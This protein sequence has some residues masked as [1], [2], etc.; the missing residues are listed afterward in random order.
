MS[1]VMTA[2]GFELRRQS[3]AKYRQ[4][5]IGSGCCGT[6]GAP[7]LPL[8]SRTRCPR[9]LEQHRL[10]QRQ[11][12]RTAEEK[13]KR[14]ARESVNKA[15]KFG[16]ITRPSTCQRCGVEAQLQAHHHDYRKYRDVEWLC[17]TC[18]SKHHRVA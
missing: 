7:V 10:R 17:V 13:Q 2:A 1:R 15:V 11:R 18:H 4:Q 6:C 12:R 9:C 3:V 8:L 5:K 14:V 16:R